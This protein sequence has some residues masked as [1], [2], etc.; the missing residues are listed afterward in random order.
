MATNRDFGSMLNQKPVTK[1]QEKKGSP[2]TQMGKK[3]GC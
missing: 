1:K 2:W 3:G